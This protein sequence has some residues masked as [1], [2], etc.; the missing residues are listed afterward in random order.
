MLLR[1]SSRYKVSG[2]H[3][4]ENLIEVFY[5]RRNFGG[6]IFNESG[7]WRYRELLNFV[8]IDTESM[9]ECSKIFGFIRRIL[10]V[11]LPDLTK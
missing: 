11:D 3:L 1:L 7:V 9:Q 10:R 5:Q 6:N 4:I 2:C 8:D